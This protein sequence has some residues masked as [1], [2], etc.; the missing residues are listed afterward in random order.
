MNI[1]VI[2]YICGYAVRIEICQPLQKD[3]SQ[4]EE[5]NMEEKVFNREATYGMYQSVKETAIA[6]YHEF[7]QESGTPMENQTAFLMKLLADN[8][9]TEYGKQYGFRKSGALKIF[10][11]EFR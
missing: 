7:L 1:S 11:R 5:F 10:R 4:K 9:D 2:Y 6:A 8:K 3:K